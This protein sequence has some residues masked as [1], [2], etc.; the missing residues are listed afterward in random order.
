M[1]YNLSSIAVIRFAFSMFMIFYY[2]PGASALL[3]VGML[4]LLWIARFTHKRSD[5]LY[6]KMKNIWEDASRQESKMVMEK[7]LIN[8]S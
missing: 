6:E 1:I 3:V 4:L 5:P 7:Q 2:L 8:L